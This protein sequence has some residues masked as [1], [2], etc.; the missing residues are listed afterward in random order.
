MAEI[1]M[2]RPL[3][4]LIAVIRRLARDRRGNVAMMF[5]LMLM[6]LVLAAGVGSD[7]AQALNFKSQLQ[8]AADDAALA[9]ASIYTPTSSTGQVTQVADNYMSNAIKSLPANKGV[10]YTA[11]PAIVTSGATTTG[12]TVAVTAT[13][14]VST[15]FMAL[16]GITTMNV[17]VSAT[18]ENPVV[19]GTF[20][21][22]G[23][24]SFAC[25]LNEVYWYVVPS[26]GGVPPKAAMNLLW[27]N[28]SAAPPASV[29]F[30]VVASQ[31]IGFALENTTGG[32]NPALGGCNYGNNMYG[33]HPGD[34]QWLYSSLQPP[35]K[36]W[37]V[38][39]GGG[40][41]G[42]HGV[43]ETT[44]DCAL[45]VEQ[46]VTVGGKTT[47]PAAPQNT[48][49]TSSGSGENTDVFNG[50]GN[51]TGICNNCGNSGATTMTTV[52]K[53]AAPSCAGLGGN[54]YQYDWN[55]MGAPVDSYNYGNDM[56]YTF[57]CAG[58]GSGN[59]GVNSAGVI[60]IK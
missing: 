30:S 33:S 13:A 25:D 36:S 23:F 51:L 55:D 14:Q 31:Q 5:G 26:G 11:T 16:G 12:Y 9:G 43:Y 4:C 10:T 53:N 34:T 60:L 39:P 17:S 54:T 1:G 50:A 22:G 6:P 48:C 57:S 37:N 28:N 47:F 44:Q 42:T 59:A 19:T 56:Q 32:R 21:T 29:N 27:S 46:G 20:N 15:S 40:G 2:M 52:M 35:S 3:K 38:A 45:V 18:A 41:T 8:A 49:F 7:Y 58:N 24:V